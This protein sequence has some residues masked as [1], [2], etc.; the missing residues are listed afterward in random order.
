MNKEPTNLD[1]LLEQSIDLD[2]RCAILNGEVSEEMVKKFMID[3][4]ALAKD[5]QPITLLINSWGGSEMDGYAIFDMI[6]SV[7]NTTIGV[8]VGQAMSTASIILQAC[9]HRVIMP[10]SWIMVHAGST[11]LDDHSI[12]VEVEG[13][14]IKKLRMKMISIY[15]ER[16]GHRKSDWNRWTKFNK[17]YNAE[18]ALKIGLVDKIGFQFKG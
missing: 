15:A 6:K 14:Q 7:P 9:T 2:Y 13:E 12:N 1:Y 10:N 5:P 16:S 18:E 17:Y 8:V 3:I 11:A 4:L